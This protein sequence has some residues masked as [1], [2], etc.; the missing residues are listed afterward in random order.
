M[1]KYL[2]IAA[3]ADAVVASV[4]EPV[5]EKVAS[6]AGT[7]HKTDI[8]QQ[9]KL[10]ADKLRNHTDSGVTDQDVHELLE[11]LHKYAAG[12]VGATLGSLSGSPAGAA[13][14]GGLSSPINASAPGPAPS[15]P[16]GQIAPKLASVPGAQLRKL[17]LE[18]RTHGEHQDEARL[19]KAAQVIVAGKTLKQITA[20]LR[21]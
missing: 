5:A 14:G 9:L 19:V 16:T 7:T 2:D 17:A 12:S 4:A 21:R 11:G 20:A 6:A 15:N 13:M 10:A 3:L 18:I 8:G 1:S